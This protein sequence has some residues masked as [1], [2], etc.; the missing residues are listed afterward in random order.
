MSPAPP[1]SPVISCRVSSRS[2]CT[3]PSSPSGDS[4]PA[5]GATELVEKLLLPDAVVERNAEGV[6]VGANALDEPEAGVDRVDDSPV[7]FRDRLTQS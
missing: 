1:E 7:V 2:E 4:G 3:I 6:L 5:F